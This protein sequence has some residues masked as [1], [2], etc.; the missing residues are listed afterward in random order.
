MRTIVVPELTR[1]R[2]VDENELLSQETS[3]DD[4][5]PISEA[6]NLHPAVIVADGLMKVLEPN[7]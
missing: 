2:L 7:E 4:W 3:V 6:E 1:R 5:N